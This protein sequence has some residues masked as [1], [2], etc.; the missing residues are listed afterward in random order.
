MN[1]NDL[2]PVQIPCPYCGERGNHKD[3]CELSLARSGLIYEV[4]A[5][6]H[7]PEESLWGT[8]DDS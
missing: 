6:P 8:G 3:I 5:I 4:V 1:A 7:R 2:A